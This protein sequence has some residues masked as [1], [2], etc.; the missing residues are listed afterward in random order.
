MS[1]RGCEQEGVNSHL[2][3]H[4]IRGTVFTQVLYSSPDPVP[5]PRNVVSFPLLPPGPK[6][7]RGLSTG[8][9]ESLRDLREGV[10]CQVCMVER[11]GHQPCGEWWAGVSG[12]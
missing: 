4:V 12:E 11:L 5:C 1:R 9:R 7:L 8:G 2:C 6:A 3:R 10:T